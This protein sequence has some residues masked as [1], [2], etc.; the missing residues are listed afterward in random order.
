M[1]LS[2]H[3]VELIEGQFNFRYRVATHFIE[4]SR[5]CH[6]PVRKASLHLDEAARTDLNRDM[7]VLMEGS[8]AGTNGTLLIPSIY[9]E[10]IVTT[11]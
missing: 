6:G 7:T 11:A 3:T 8:N 5:T 10:V 1:P 2:I 9:A 4:V